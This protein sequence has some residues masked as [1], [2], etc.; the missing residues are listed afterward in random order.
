M[1]KIFISIAFAVL[2]F[3]GLGSLVDKA[4]ARFRSDERALVLLKQARLAIGGEQAVANVR[5]MTISGRTAK[6]FSLNGTSRTE[7]GQ[8]EIAMQMPDKFSK[9]IK[10]G[11]GDGSTAGEQLLSQQHDVIILKKG[12]VVPSGKT[13]DFITED[14]KRVIVTTVEGQQNGNATF[15]VTDSGEKVGNPVAKKVIVE[16]SEVGDAASASQN[17]ITIVRKSLDENVD[18]TAKSGEKMKIGTPDSPA[19]FGQMRMAHTG[20]RHNELLKTTLGLLLSAPEGMDVSY[21]FAGEADVDGNACNVISADFAGESIKI[22]LSKAS[23]LPLMLSYKAEPM[24]NIF[25]FK[26]DKAGA[27]DAQKENVVIAR[28][29]AVQKSNTVEYQMR[30]SDYRSVNGVQLP[31]RWTTTASGQP[32]EVFEVTNYELNPAN[33]ADRFSNQKV[34]IRSKK[35]GN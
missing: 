9:T 18:W 24:V 7:D 30:F 25:H 5:S 28:Q 23:S 4:G 29:P 34:M 14:G 33:I 20:S 11:G 1:K 21:N 16:R 32:D 17:Q 19:G 31:Y 35:E 10:I 27:G 8:I 15:I 26:R 22:Y 12:E 2:F 3:A 6:T 13:G